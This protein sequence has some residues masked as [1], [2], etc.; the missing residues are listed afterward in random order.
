MDIVI[1]LTLWAFIFTD[2]N[3]TGEDFVHLTEISFER[4]H[5]SF[6]ETVGLVKVVKSL[7]Q[8]YE[9]KA[10]IIGAKKKKGIRG[11]IYRHAQEHGARYSLDRS[12]S[13]YYSDDDS[14][15]LEIVLLFCERVEA[16]SF[17][18]F[19]SLWYLNN[20]LLVQPGDILVQDSIKI[21]HVVGSD[22]IKVLLSH[23]DAT[24]S[25]SPIQTLKELSVIPSSDSHIS[26][27]SLKSPTAEFQSIE[28]P[29]T[30]SCKRPIKCHIKPR[31]DFKKLI[32][33]ENNLLAMSRDFHDYFDGMMTVDCETGINDIPM[34][35]IK[36]PEEHNC[37]DELVSGMKRK[38][39]E[40]VVECRNREIGGIVE[41]SLKMGSV[42]VSDT[43][44]KTFVHVED[45]ITF[46]DCLDWKYKNACEIW[47]AVDED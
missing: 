47:K 16:D 22:L 32:N 23:Y 42:K 45:A 34:I 12:K 36:P 43:Q 37:E 8:C 41:K 38:R 20:P 25:E 30:F 18:N 7:M 35:A 2:A 19:L 29:E 31:S 4:L 9:V 33:N 46:C 17:A 6:T 40:L 39:V 3:V 1:I 26:A 5:F 21:V 44:F 15:N 14:N 13:I 10:K 24:E 28:R 27:F 11:L